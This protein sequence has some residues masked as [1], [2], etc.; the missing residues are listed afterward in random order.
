VNIH[1]GDTFTLTTDDPESHPLP[2]L[3]LLDMQW[4]LQRLVAMCGAAEWPWIEADDDS[5]HFYNY[6]YAGPTYSHIPE[7]A[8]KYPN[9][10]QWI[11]DPGISVEVF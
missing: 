4:V 3:E 5:D 2:S 6:N 7:D 8:E 10:C 9:I 1:S 11:P